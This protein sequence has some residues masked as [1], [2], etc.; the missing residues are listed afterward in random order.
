MAVVQDRS[1]DLCP[2]SLMVRR[3]GSAKERRGHVLPMDIEVPAL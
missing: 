1:G 2:W 3:A